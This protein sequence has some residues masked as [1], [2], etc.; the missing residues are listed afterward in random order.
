[1]FNV[2]HWKFMYLYIYYRFIRGHQ[3]GRLLSRECYGANRKYGL[4]SNV[5]SASRRP[6]S[7]HEHVGYHR[8][9]W[10]HD[11]HGPRWQWL[12]I[13]LHITHGFWEIFNANG[14]T[15]SLCGKK[16]LIICRHKWQWSHLR[17]F[18]SWGTV[19]NTRRQRLVNVV[20]SNRNKGWYS[21]RD[22]CP[23]NKAWD[24]FGERRRGV[25]LRV[26]K[27]RRCC[28]FSVRSHAGLPWHIAIFTKFEVDCRR[29]SGNK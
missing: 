27:Q 8:I 29:N 10:R 4:Y 11:I 2:R 24:Y 19:S 16:K 28:T 23:F 14:E 1:M 21:E 17:W 12:R 3:D 25:V 7:Q 6:R 13:V 20:K 22:L 26:H 15:S 9:Q 18:C 5:G